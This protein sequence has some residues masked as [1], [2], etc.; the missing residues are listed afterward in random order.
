MVTLILLFVF[1]SPHLIDFHDRPIPEVPQRS[2]E[3][4]VRDAGGSGDGHR[5]VYEIRADDLNGARSPQEL[6]T[7]IEEIVKNIAGDAEI[8]TVK[9]VVDPHKRIVAYDVSVRR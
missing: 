4:L 3:V 7:H 6:Q 5:F 1:I 2:S 8:D 9:P